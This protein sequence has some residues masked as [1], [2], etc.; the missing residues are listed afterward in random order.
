MLELCAMLVSVSSS[1]QF[2]RFAR[3]SGSFVLRLYFRH[4][5]RLVRYSMI[6]AFS[7]LLSA[8]LGTAQAADDPK[9][10]LADGLYAKIDT[11]RGTILLRLFYEKTPL[12]AANF[13]G[14]AEGQLPAYRGGKA[15]PLKKFYDGLTFHRV[16][17]NFM[18][19]GGD[20]QGDGRGGPGYRFADEFVASLKH[21]RPGILSMANAGPQTNGSQFFITRVPTPW[22][23]GKHTVF[24]EVIRGQDVIEA[25]RQ[26]DKI[27][28]V[29]IE[30]VGKA[31]SE[32][33]AVAIFKERE[34][35]GQIR[36]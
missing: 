27:Q 14:L 13:V 19:Q 12:T 22:L 7:T 15:L 35:Q 17:P 20:P 10:N 25:T 32:F 33:D 11:A 23:D 28:T 1:G 21:D 2:R 4:F 31:A 18:V 34:R 5:A 24:G 6:L 26:G 8:P 16:I 3:R 29:T 36:R 9:K 30:R